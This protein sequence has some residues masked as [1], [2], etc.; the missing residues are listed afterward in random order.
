[1]KTSKR[2]LLLAIAV[3][4]MAA[5]GA[6]QDAVEWVWSGAVT[7][8]SATV[9]AK[10]RA[11]AT[12]VRL[13]VSD[14]ADLE[15]ARPVPEKGYAAPDADGVVSFSLDALRPDT[16]YFY[17]VEL[18]GQRALG[19][20]FRSFT[21]EPKSFQ[22][23]FG[24]CATTGSNHE[25][26]DTMREL[27]LILMI[28]MGDFHYENIKDNDPRKFRE[29]F[30]RVL[31]SERQSPLYR[32]APIAYVWDDHDFG[33]N[34][35][36]KNSP[37]KPAALATY[38]QYVPH[39]PLVRETG[40]VRTIQQAFT[41]GRLRFVMTDG[42]AE[43]DPVEDADG[44]EK[45]LLGQAQR[46][47]LFAE[48]ER[49]KRELAV[50]VWVNVVPW[51]TKSQ[52]GSDHGWEPYGHERRLIADRIKALDLVDRLLILSGD[53]HMV[54]IDD[55]TNSNYATDREPDERAFP[56]VHAPRWIGFH[57]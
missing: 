30:D 48:L 45:S 21:S 32:H 51:I 39:Y 11:G 3:L 36:D 4:T 25:I 56:V 52:V 18:G 42:R 26:F 53:G 7:A 49:A 44:P 2:I 28:H 43:K 46:E 55:G 47:W 13:A 57:V 14:N 50:I 8:R 34:D 12:G 16:L 15:N 40:A 22:L 9:K 38:Q 35:A 6:S 10:V 41:L 33:P 19:G 27:D 5:P 1:M 29:A 54:A 17:S 37:G 20:Q 31:A 23:V 24:S